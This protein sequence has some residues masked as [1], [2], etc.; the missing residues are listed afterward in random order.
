[1]PTAEHVRDRTL[2]TI[3]VARERAEDLVS[4]GTHGLAVAVNRAVDEV[5]EHRPEIELPS[6][7]VPSVDDLVHHATTHKLRT[8]LIVSVVV[9][10]LLVLV[11]KL[12]TSADDPAPTTS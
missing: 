3:E 6:V 7:D 8:T 4:S 10:A 2:D 5:R 12:T 9:L 11:R 1:M